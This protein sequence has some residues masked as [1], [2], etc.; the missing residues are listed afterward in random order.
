MRVITVKRWREKLFV[1]LV[2]VVIIG[3]LSWG[4]SKFVSFDSTTAT[5]PTD[6]LQDDV[7]LQPVKVQGEQ[8]HD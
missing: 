7:L 4:L 1:L 3:G 2:A 8:L 6:S 5:T